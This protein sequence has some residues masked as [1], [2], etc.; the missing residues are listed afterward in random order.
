MNMK[1]SVDSILA[2]HT[3]QQTEAI[4][5]KLEKF[6]I[7]S[8]EEPPPKKRRTKLREKKLIFSYVKQNCDCVAYS[9]Y[10]AE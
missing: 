1:L 8:S 7:D 10:Q 2:E 9:F 3:K 4:F 6:E 5:E